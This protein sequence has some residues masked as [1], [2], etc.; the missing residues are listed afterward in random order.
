MPLAELQA[1]LCVQPLVLTCIVNFEDMMAQ[2]KTR[3]ARCSASCYQR[4]LQTFLN[5]MG[6][7]KF[8][9]KCSNRLC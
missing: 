5:M 2:R 1:S 7:V 8:F 6:V 4:C 9:S 3:E